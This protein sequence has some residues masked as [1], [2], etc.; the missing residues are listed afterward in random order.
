MEHEQLGKQSQNKKMNKNCNL[1]VN[2]NNIATNESILIP[3]NK[4]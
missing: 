1:N 2:L 3:V 4:I